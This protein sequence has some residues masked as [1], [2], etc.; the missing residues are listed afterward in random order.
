MDLF[1]F[2]VLV[3]IVM[4]LFLYFLLDFFAFAL[5]LPLLLQRVAT[6]YISPSAELTGR[7]VFWRLRRFLHRFGSQ[8]D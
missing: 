3:L 4:L 1:Y 8:N 2:L 5:V 6:F 7:R